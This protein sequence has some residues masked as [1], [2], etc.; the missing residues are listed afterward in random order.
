GDT[1]GV[2][3]TMRRLAAAA[4]PDITV[5][6]S[7]DP[8]GERPGLIALDAEW[9]LPLPTSEHLDL[10]FPSLLDVL[11]RVEATRP[12]VIQ[13]ATP[14]P[15]G[16][17]GLMVAKLLGIPVLGSYHTELGPYALHLTRDLLVAEAMSNYVDWF[18]GRCDA[19]LAPTSAVADELARRGVTE[20]VRVWSRGVDTQLFTPAR[21]DEAL[22][23]RLG[24]GGPVLPPPVGRVLPQKSP[25]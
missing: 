21:R 24:G 7:G 25:A 9:S 15:V 12:D 19:V 4:A 5:V 2:A 18:Y 10:R 8:P 14:G 16:A 11:R 3:G 22:R 6:A 1:N 20:R 23:A 13:V 17:C